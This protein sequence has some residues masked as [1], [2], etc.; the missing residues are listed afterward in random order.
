MYSIWN[1]NNRHGRLT[2]QNWARDSFIMTL[3]LLTLDSLEEKH[4]AGLI[5]S[6]FEY[7]VA[8]VVVEP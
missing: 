4:P 3:V 2:Q 7:V 8:I 5:L 1:G 6:V